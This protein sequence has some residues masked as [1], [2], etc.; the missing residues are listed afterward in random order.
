MDN[1]IYEPLAMNSRNGVVHGKL[2]GT[3]ETFSFV[4]SFII[5]TRDER[6][7]LFI[8]RADPVRQRKT[9]IVRRGNNQRRTAFKGMTSGLRAEGLD[10]E[11]LKGTFPILTRAKRENGPQ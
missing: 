11:R 9:D 7:C 8:G 6:A 1:Y 4:L 5:N 10:F 2:C 3:A